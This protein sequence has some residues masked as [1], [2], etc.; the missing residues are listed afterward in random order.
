MYT[1]EKCNKEFKRYDNYKRHMNRKTPCNSKKNYSC[2]KCE[3]TFPDKTRYTNHIN[4]KYPCKSM[5]ELLLEKEVE[6]LELKN[7]VLELKYEM[8]L[9]SGQTVN[10]HNTT[11]QTNCNNDNSITNNDNSVINNTNLTLNNYGKEDVS[12]ITP[13]MTNCLLLA[14]VQG[15][16][17]LFKL[18]HYNNDH[19][20]NKTLK[21][22]DLSRDKIGV[23]DGYED[24]KELWSD[25]TK[26]K[27]TTNHI[28]RSHEMHKN[29]LRPKG[30][31]NVT[32]Q[33]RECLR[34]LATP[35]SMYK[36]QTQDGIIEVMKE[37]RHELI[38]C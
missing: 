1:C 10:S 24:G 25:I 17:E 9:M 8:V 2:P 14:G 27:I 36:K 31:E 32:Q 5:N 12:Y 6:N 13:K 4:R 3:K 15:S 23:F 34:E 26:E 29:A 33:E 37:H 22:K 35:S 20:E 19:P 21:I 28:E 30:V 7:Q 16:I 11:T 38:V 18:I